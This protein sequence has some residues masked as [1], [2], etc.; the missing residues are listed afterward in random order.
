MERAGRLAGRQAAAGQPRAAGAAGELRRRLRQR[1]LGTGARHRAGRRAAAGARAR[2]SIVPLKHWDGNVFSVSFVTENSPPGTISKA[3]FDGN[4]LTLEYYDDDGQ[5]DLHPM[6]QRDRRRALRRR[7]G[8]ARRRGQ[9][10]RRP[11]QGGAQ[12]L[13]DRPR[14]RVHPDQRDPRRAADHRAVDR[15]GDQRAVRPAHRR[16]QRDRH[17]PGAARQADA[18]QAGDRRAG[19]TGGAQAVRDRRRGRPS[20]VVLDDVIELGPGDQIVVDGEVLEEAEPRGRRVA[21]DRRGRPDR[22]GRRRQGD[23]GQL[24]RRGQRRLP[25]DEGRPRGLRRQARRGGQQ[26]H[27]GE[28]RT[29]QRHQQDPAVHHL[30]A[31]PRRAC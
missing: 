13:G 29:A 16:Q 5:G 21:A 18:G 12:R 27:A 25:R 24:R 17:H 19:E 7:G 10:Q 14:Q 20:E 31:G 15:V 22:Q 30:P 4:K 2:N 9:D 8:A 1:L 23:V 3:T 6:T 26:V 28:V 11:G